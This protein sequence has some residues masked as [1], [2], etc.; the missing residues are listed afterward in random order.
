MASEASPLDT[1]GMMRKGMP[2]SESAK[3]SSPPRPK[4]KGSPPLSRSTALALAGKLDQPLADVLLHG[5]GLAAALAGEFEEGAF[6]GEGEDGR[7]DQRVVDDDVRHREGVQGMDREQAGIA[8]TCA[9]EPD[10]AR[11]EGGRE[12]GQ[13]GHAD[14]RAWPATPRWL[15]EFIGTL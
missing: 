4:M 7:V 1:P 9:H 14:L 8:R 3:A 15:L 2:A 12:A 11:C 10:R 13:G 5:R 6:A